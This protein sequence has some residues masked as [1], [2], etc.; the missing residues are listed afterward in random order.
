MKKQILS[1]AAAAALLTTGA[2]AFDMQTDGTIIDDIRSASPKAAV[3]TKGKNAIDPL[4]LST[5]M[6][7]NALIYPAFKSDGGWS[8]EISLR[9]TKDVAIIA[10]VVLYAQNDSRELLDFNLYL[11][12]HDAVKFTIKD[13]KIVSTDGSIARL[14]KDPTGGITKDDVRFASETD[15]L[16]AKFSTNAPAGYV[17]I[18]AMMQQD[19]DDTKTSEENMKVYHLNHKD[20]FKDYRKTLDVC[21]ELDQDTSTDATWRETFNLKPDAEYVSNGTAIN[22]GKI[23]APNQL[24][25]CAEENAAFTGSWARKAGFTSPSDDALFGEV[26]ISHTGDK[27]SVLLPATALSNYVEDGKVMLWAEGEY[28]SIQDRRIDGNH[29]DKVGLL[30]DAKTFEISKTYFTFDKKESERNHAT[31]LLTQPMKRALQMADQ[32]DDYWKKKRIST[33]AWGEFALNRTPWTDDEGTI[34]PETVPDAEF[35]SL[36]S[37]LTGTTAPV[38]DEDG[39]GAELTVLNYK[40]LTERFDEVFKDNNGNA[41]AGYIDLKI[42]NT[43]NKLPAIVTQMTSTDIDGESQI[44]WVYSVTE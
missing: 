4:T 6:K 10:K 39:Y 22:K 24:N 37:P 3:Y 30:N 19:L 28:A 41:V 31:L 7:G 27:R 35:G 32:G 11:S 8:T 25:A 16:T 5:N 20:L 36:N 21:R 29:Y 12:P 23:L 2:T 14:V 44:N 1:I 15:P 26:S 18:Y 13:N 43:V 9:N 17:I 34:T 38:A 42:V 33:E 40:I